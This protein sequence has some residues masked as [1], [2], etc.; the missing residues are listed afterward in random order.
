M[1][2]AIK[3]LKLVWP[4]LV[5]LACFAVACLFPDEWI[6]SLPLHAILKVIGKLPGMSWLEWLY[7]EGQ[8]QVT[9]FRIGLVAA[10][11]VCAVGVAF[12]DYSEFF[13]KR[14]GI[15]VYFDNQ[16]IQDVLNKYSSKELKRLN[17]MTAWEPE[18]EAY[19]KRLNQK[20]E[21]GG[22]NF[23]FSNGYPPT[24][25]SGQG[26]LAGEKVK[27]W[28][29]QKY[30]IVEGSGNLSFETRAQPLHLRTT[31]ELADS[32]GN[33]VE[34]GMLDVFLMRP[35]MIMPEFHQVFHRTIEAQDEFDHIL[36]T[37][38]KIK[39]LPIIDLGSTLYL[40]PQENGFRIPIGYAVYG[41]DQ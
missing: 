22:F 15:T 32:R 23:R 4:G 36:V 2:S 5:G 17:L 24:L 27:R 6:A 19:F 28:G 31:Y 10:S 33:D 41:P 37:A 35:M 39:F 12:R 40:Y 9:P 1:D 16:G 30:K 21:S 20:L 14:F 25:G 34:A 18:K 11:V 38:T 26:T 3:Q 29:F 8:V 7:P 13:P